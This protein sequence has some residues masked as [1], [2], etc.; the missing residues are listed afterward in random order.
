MSPMSTERYYLTFMMV[1]P[2]RSGKT[3]GDEMVSVTESAVAEFKKVLEREKKSGHGFRIFIAN[4]G[5]CGPEYGIGFEEKAQESDTVFED[6]GVKFFLDE[7]AH[8]ALDGSIVDY[9]ETP[10]GSGFVINN[11]NACSSCGSSSDSC[12]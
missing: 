9:T 3:T 10:Y 6:H 2:C 5:C 1:I 8:R 7:N 11:P 4:I 12:H